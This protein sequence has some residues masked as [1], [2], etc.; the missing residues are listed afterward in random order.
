MAKNHQTAPKR[1]FSD[2]PALSFSARYRGACWLLNLILYTLLN[3]Y[4]LRMLTGTW[5]SPVPPL[6][7]QTLIE[8]LPLNVFHFPSLI[9]VIALIM[10]LLCTA[11]LITAQF[12]NLLYAVPFVLVTLFLGQ[13]RGLSLC[14]FV[15][16][17]A[18]SFEPLRFKSK[19]VAAL[20]CLLPEILYWI[21]FAGPNP[22]QDALRWAVLYAPWGLAFLFCVTIIGIVIA[23]GH[24]LRYRPGV[25]TPVFGLLLAGTVLLFHLTIG[26][27]ERDFQ[28]QVYRNNPDQIAAFKNRSIVPL[29]EKELA[30]RL[31]KESYLEEE[32]VKEQIRR[33]WRQAFL[34]TRMEFPVGIDYSTPASREVLNFYQ[35]KSE[36]IEHLD[37]F[38]NNSSPQDKRQS[39]AYYYRA[40]LIDVSVDLRALRDEDLLR[41][42][43]DIPGPDSEK[44]WQQIIN[45]FPD[46]PVSIEARWRLA[47]LWAA[48]KSDSALQ[49]FRFDEALGLLQQARQLCDDLIQRRKETAARENFSNGFFA[50]I[51]S[52]P[53][54]ALNNEQLASLQMRIGRLMTLI[55]P[56]NRT[57][58]DQNQQRLAQFVRL[59]KF[60]LNYE[61]LLKEMTLD[62]PRPD[63]L[64]DNIELAQVLLLK[65]TEEKITRLEDL[66]QRYQ[67][68]D[69]GVEAMLELAQTLM[70]KYRRSDYQGDRDL[71]LSRSTEL[72]QKIIFL[73]PEEF[74]GQYAQKKL[75]ELPPVK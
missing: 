43:Y 54:P 8:Q 55:N 9:V 7:T 56:E 34:M 44:L 63:P 51:F 64:L 61:A 69:G 60:N 21:L 68:R 49:P 27:Q 19:F 14:L 32:I 13:N 47:R 18:V 50:Q 17:A 46:A 45:Q 2:G 35:A 74:L 31:K 40:L 28:A 20:L 6:H 75:E 26:M 30:Q 36:A 15:S 65:D 23:I 52:P 39:D 72:L 10:G 59:D 1:W 62:S 29:L 22:E 5:L 37:D 25:L 57:G 41:F 16:C 73:R 53:P 38:I 11:P 48:E 58:P 33:N 3:M 70:E 71:L 67:D 24:F 4:Y 42:S 66:I 12:Y